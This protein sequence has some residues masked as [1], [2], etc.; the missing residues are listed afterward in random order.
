MAMVLCGVTPPLLPAGLALVLDMD[1]V[2]VDSNPVHL[3]A[4]EQYLASY[5][6]T[7]PDLPQRMVGKRNDQIVR[8]FFPYP[9]TDEEVFAH[10]ARKEALYRELAGARL[11]ELLTPGLVAFL[12]RHSAA[13]K[14]L[15]T[16]A[17]PANVDFVL[18]GAGLR[19][20]FPVTVNGHQVT[21]PKPHPEAYERAF[22]L[23]DIPAARCVVFEDS[24]SGATAGHAAGARVV[25]VRLDTSTC[26]VISLTIQDFLDPAL[27]PWLGQLRH[28]A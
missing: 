2:I 19:P 12:E 8:G 24:S 20:Y 10:G 11:P 21:N 7:V 5:S 27:E 9:L 1:G 26:S 22:R 16:N 14:A 13:P 15:V 3:E 6:I 25:G 28:S 4:W 18:D 17:E 23:L